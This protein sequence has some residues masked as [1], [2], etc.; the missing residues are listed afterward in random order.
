MIAII[1][2]STK[3]YLFIVCIWNCCQRWLLKRNT[4]TVTALAAAS[5]LRVMAAESW[6]S[7][8]AVSDTGLKTAGASTT[9]SVLHVWKAQPTKTIG[10][11]C[12]TSTHLTV[13]VQ[14]KWSVSTSADLCFTRDS[15]FLSSFFVSYTR[16]SL[17]GLKWQ[18][19]AIIATFLIYIF[20]KFTNCYTQINMLAN[21]KCTVQRKNTRRCS[22][23]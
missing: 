16:S 10:Q 17:N 19:I 14:H 3:Q 4:A 23:S 8:N 5:R 13:S 11:H 22:L 21:L 15:F 18:C 1:Y 7:T 2:L 6:L 9:E 12:I 20:S